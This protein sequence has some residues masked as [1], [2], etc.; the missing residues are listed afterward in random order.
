MILMYFCWGHICVFFPCVIY[1]HQ[2]LIRKD[3]FGPYPGE[4]IA[5]LSYYMKIYSLR[6]KK[7]TSFVQLHHKIAS[8][9][10]VTKLFFL[11]NLSWVWLFMYNVFIYFHIILVFLV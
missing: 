3:H 10:F 5:F 9:I 11:K 1:I 2:E 6:E 7:K 4:Y 8:D